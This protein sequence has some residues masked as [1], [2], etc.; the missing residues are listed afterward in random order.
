MTGKVSE[1]ERF[2]SQG[3]DI[4]PDDE[5]IRREPEEMSGAPSTPSLLTGFF[6]YCD[7]DVGSD[8]QCFRDR[9]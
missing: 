7:T 3:K 8:T 4:T 1:P 9:D 5:Y 6:Y 2:E